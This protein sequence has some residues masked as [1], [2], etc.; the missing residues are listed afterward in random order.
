MERRLSKLSRRDPEIL[1]LGKQ[2]KQLYIFKI[3]T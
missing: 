3:K 2:K 1:E